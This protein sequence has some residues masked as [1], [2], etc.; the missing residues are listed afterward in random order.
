[1]PDKLKTPEARTFFELYRALTAEGRMPPK[2]ALTP[3]YV[4]PVMR[5]VFI[6]EA[7]PE[8]YYFR[9][10]GS[11]IARI[12]GR[13]NSRKYLH[14][15][16]E[17]ADLEHVEAIHDDCLRRRV[18]IASFER[19]KDPGNRSVEVEI[20]RC[21]FADAAGVPRFVA[22]TFAAIGYS[23]PERPGKVISRRDLVIERD[24]AP[25]MEFPAVEA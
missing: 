2:S 10:F 13:E 22:G 11:E 18:V 23:I 12:V 25:R 19:L 6:V 17:G 7:R 1:V 21:P 3:E 24:A 8:G 4:R 20:L 5:N 9:L 15:L 14:E 16:L